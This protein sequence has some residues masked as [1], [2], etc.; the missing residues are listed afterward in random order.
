[1]T[2]SSDNTSTNKTS[3]LDRLLYLVVFL[4]SALQPFSWPWKRRAYVSMHFPGPGDIT[5]SNPKTPRRSG[6]I[7]GRGHLNLD[8]YEW[9]LQRLSYK[10]SV[11]DPVCFRGLWSLSLTE[12]T[13][14]FI[15]A[16]RQ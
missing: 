10:V 6:N 2:A 12:S 1:M 15:V 11:F 9:L 5:V 16:Q 4:V 8:T 14:Y 3:P 7:A 13:T